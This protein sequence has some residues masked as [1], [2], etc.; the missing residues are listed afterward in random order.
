MQELRKPESCPR[1]GGRA[2]K[3]IVGGRPSEEG[4]AMI[5]RGEAI[6]GTCF[7]SLD[8]PDWHCAV[9]GHQWFDPTDPARQE[10]D[11]LFRRIFQKGNEN[12]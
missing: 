4:W 7:A 9:C 8:R 11:E 12:A 3:R 10:V 1:C 6:A 2:I 5:E